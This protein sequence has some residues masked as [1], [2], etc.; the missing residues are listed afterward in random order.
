MVTTVGAEIMLEYATWHD[1]MRFTMPRVL[2]H[3]NLN[4]LN[5]FLVFDFNLCDHIIGFNI[6]FHYEDRRLTAALFR[7]KHFKQRDLLIFLKN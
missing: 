4:G 3:T 2:N 6:L 5:R 1:W 7:L